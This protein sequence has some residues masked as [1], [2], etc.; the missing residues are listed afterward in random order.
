MGQSEE[1]SV[2]VQK[3]LEEGKWEEAATLAEATGQVAPIL[4]GVWPSDRYYIQRR[5][6]LIQAAAKLLNSAY[7]TQAAEKL[8]LAVF[9]GIRNKLENKI[10]VNTKDRF[11]SGRNTEVCFVC[12]AEL[13]RFLRGAY[14]DGCGELTW[15]DFQELVAAGYN[16]VGSGRL[17][18]DSLFFGAAATAARLG[19]T[20]L[21]KALAEKEARSSGLDFYGRW[22]REMLKGEREIEWGEFEGVILCR[23]C[24]EDV[25]TFLRART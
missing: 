18:P 5:L 25:L 20:N 13:R 2:E 4:E 12:R 24:K 23:S 8:K 10:G 9:R 14:Y 1:A 15:E 22:K 7:G 19:Q 3:L 17:R 6:G 11:W 16:P 21:A